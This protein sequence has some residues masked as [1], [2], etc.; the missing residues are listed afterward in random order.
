MSIGE[1]ERTA[2]EAKMG[3]S[4][5]SSLAECFTQRRYVRL[6]SVSS[7]CGMIGGT[8]CVAAGR[9]VRS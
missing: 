7:A 4:K 9:M 6:V 1:H 2:G 3:V 8:R 5:R